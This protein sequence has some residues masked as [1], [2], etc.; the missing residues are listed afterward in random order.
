VTA[1]DEYSERKH[2][3]LA[4]PQ[5]EGQKIGFAYIKAEENSEVQ[6]PFFV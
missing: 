4:Q 2:R 5:C 6:L 3:D 1:N